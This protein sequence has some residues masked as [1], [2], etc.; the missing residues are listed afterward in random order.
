MTAPRWSRWL[1]T[2]VAP[3]DRVDELLGDVEE[4]YQRHRARRGWLGAQL[5]GARETLELAS[6]LMREQARRRGVWD[7]SPSSK[8]SVSALDVKLGLRMLRKHPALSIVSVLGMSVAIGIGAAGF[9]LLSSAMDPTLPLS[10]GE[11]IVSVLNNTR[12]PGNPERHVLHDF[13]LWRERVKSVRELSAFTEATRNLVMPSGAVELVGVAE[14][15]ASGFGVARV[16]PLL[17]RPLL[18]EDEQPNA[19]A[20]IV[21]GYD[22]WQR[23]FKGDRAVLGRQLQLGREHRTVVGVMPEGYHF[24]VNHSYWVPLRIP[25]SPPPVGKGPSINVFG[26]LAEGATLETARAELRTIRAGLAAAYPETYEFLRPD[27][28]RYTHPFTE[29]D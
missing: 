14:M 15:T 8:G 18:P 9:E 21:I 28:M 7:E 3:H 19:P 27:V 25:A 6:A 13:V 20:V 12:N 2:R 1:V 5:S 10:G 22:A 4:V 23:H 17:G 29:V 24:P 26:R 11:R 16:Q